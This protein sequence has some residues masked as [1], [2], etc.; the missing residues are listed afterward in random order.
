MTP[1]LEVELGLGGLVPGVQGTLIPHSDVAMAA[2]VHM[3]SRAADGH[4]I[5][6]LSVAEFANL[7][8]PTWS[9]LPDHCF[10]WNGRLGGQ[11]RVI[12]LTCLYPQRG[13]PALPSDTIPKPSS[14]SSSLTPGRELVLIWSP[15]TIDPLCTSPG[16]PPW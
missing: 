7:P 9:P 13:Q 12:A 5:D 15:H 3:V 1:H 14:D 2:R 4:S 6:F 11:E 16:F 10:V 8:G